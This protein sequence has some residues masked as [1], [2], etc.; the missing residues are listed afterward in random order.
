[1]VEWSP[2]LRRQ[3]GHELVST[4]ALLDE[5]QRPGS[6]LVELVDLIAGQIHEHHRVAQPPSHYF[7][8]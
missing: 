7:R 4:D 1:M 8:V 2:E 5:L 6:S 3:A